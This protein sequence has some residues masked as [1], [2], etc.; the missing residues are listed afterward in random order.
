MPT[1][2]NGYLVFDGMGRKANSPSNVLWVDLAEK[3]YVQMNEMGWIRPWQWG[4]GQNKYTG[5]SGGCMYMAM[6]QIT[7]QAT[8]A[9]AS[10]ASS[11]SFSLCGGVQRRQGNLLR[12]E[13]R[14]TK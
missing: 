7:G 8:V 4:G 3:A 14:S 2:A 1:D 11:S 12:L 13:G 10:T 5:I 6:A 9:F